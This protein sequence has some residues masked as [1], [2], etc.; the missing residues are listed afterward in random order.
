M[1]VEFLAPT[2]FSPV[3]NTIIE[4]IK[5][6]KDESFNYHILLIISDGNI[7]DIVETIDSIIESSKLPLSFIII[8]VGD[9]IPSDMRELNGEYGKLISSNG[10]ILDRDIVQ[11]IHYNDY[12][13]YINKLSEDALKYI[14]EQITNYYKDKLIE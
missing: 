14:P 3:I 6:K 5:D 10:E 7:Y 11:Y 13:E 8:G 2:Y 1:N 12:I 4:K 9:D